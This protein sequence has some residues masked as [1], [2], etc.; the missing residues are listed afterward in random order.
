[1]GPRGGQGTRGGR[2]KTVRGTGAAAGAGR[3]TSTGMKHEGMYTS[4]N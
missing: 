4:E 1:M 3:R 2:E